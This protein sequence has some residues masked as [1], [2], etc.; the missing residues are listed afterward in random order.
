MVEQRKAA[1]VPKAL[2][3]QL[4]VVLPVVESRRETQRMVTLFFPLPEP[5]DASFEPL[6]MQPGQFLMTWIPGVNEKP[7]T[8]SYLDDERFGITVLPRGQFST[9]LSQAQPGKLIGFRGP[10]GRGFW[11]MGK[12]TDD[13]ATV[14]MGGGSG[15]ASLALLAQ[16]LPRA[17]FVQGARTAAELLY[18]DR[19][20]RQVIFT[21]DGTAG[22]RAFPTEWL[23]GALA[24]GKVRAVYT[25]GPEA[26]MAPIVQMCLAAGVACQAALERYMK[27]GFGVCGQCECDGHRVCLEGPVFS[28]EELRAMPSFGSMSRLPTGQKVTAGKKQC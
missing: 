8:A 5:P 11:G 26:M 20:P 22:E 1:A 6:R 13:P 19:F 10:Y 3:T 24:A 28:S 7:F 16:R 17:T 2:R 27:C 12:G 14:L 9:E 4:P 15:T 18:R 21:D 25:C 23:R